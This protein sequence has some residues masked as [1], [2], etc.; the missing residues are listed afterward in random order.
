[1]INIQDELKEIK[2]Y[3]ENNLYED[4]V[5][6]CNY[7]FKKIP[8]SVKDFSNEPNYFH[9][10]NNDQSNRIYRA[11]KITN[12]ENQPHKY[13]KDLSYVPLDEV[14]CITK[15]G[16][17]NKVKESMFYGSLN[18]A[19]A[20]LEVLSQDQDFQKSGSAMVTIGE[21]KFET[22]LTLAQVPYSKIELSKLKEV[23]SFPLDKVNI[24]CIEKQNQQLRKQLK[25][26]LEFEI[27]NF[28]SEAFCNFSSEQDNKYY[29][30][31]YY[32][33]RVFNRIKGFASSDEVN[34]IIYPS[35]PSSY[36]EKN[37]VLK[38]EV[39][40]SK[41]KFIGAVQVWVVHRLKVKGG[42]DFYPIEHRI[43]ANEKG[44]IQW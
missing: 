38:P 26:D 10:N 19:T 25:N 20:A 6:R 27:L 11:R 16:R 36:Q 13:I 42:I 8:I 9:Q 32:A 18:Y 30:S 12:L 37:I 31:N 34:G 35:I 7:H 33:D 1:M 2:I 40:D 22:P 17:V 39:V 23:L 3:A 43:G 24:E 4:V 5:S 41:L 29:L 21:W 14:D 44:E 15:F 28:F